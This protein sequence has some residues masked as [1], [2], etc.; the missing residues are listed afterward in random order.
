MI[1]CLRQSVCKNVFLGNEEF[2]EYSQSFIEGIDRMLIFQGIIKDI[3]Y[4]SNP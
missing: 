1:V 4:L 3:N 2:N